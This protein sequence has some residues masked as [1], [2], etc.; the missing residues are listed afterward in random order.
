M[1]DQCWLLKAAFL[2]A[3]SKQ[4]RIFPIFQP[5]LS[6]LEFECLLS[7]SPLSNRPM[8]RLWPCKPYISS[9]KV[10]G[11]I[12]S[13]IS[14]ELH[15]PLWSLPKVHRKFLHPFHN[16]IFISFQRKE[17]RV[18]PVPFPAHKFGQVMPQF[19]TL[20]RGPHVLPLLCLISLPSTP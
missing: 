17:I 20:G 1:P 9:C 15:Q 16:W 7:N 2:A 6:S 11:C 19:N 14:A 18:P 5:P 13:V 10:P 4:D 3:G 8:S 12:N